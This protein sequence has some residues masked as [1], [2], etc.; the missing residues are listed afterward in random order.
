[1]HKLTDALLWLLRAYAHAV[2]QIIIVGLAGLTIA[3]A[4]LFAVDQTTEVDLLNEIWAV[5]V[6]IDDG[7]AQVN[8][9]L[10]TLIEVA[11]EG[12]DAIPAE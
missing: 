4:G 2:L 9:E 12:L 10:D 3:F 8:A 11:E 6:D 1:M 7:I 5:L